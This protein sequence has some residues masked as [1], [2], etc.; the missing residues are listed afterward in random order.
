MQR[1]LTSIQIPASTVKP[2]EAAALEALLRASQSK[3][4]MRI[5]LKPLFFAWLAMSFHFERQQHKTG[6]SFLLRLASL[7]LPVAVIDRYMKSSLDC[8]TVGLS[9]RSH[10]ICHLS[11]PAS[12]QAP[13]A[14]VCASATIAPRNV[15]FQHMTR[16]MA[17]HGFPG[18]P[19]VLRQ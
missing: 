17:G 13:G 2:A 5:D 9:A 11:L 1:I 10:P 18:P 15:L 12:L 7:R 6:E 19:R 8:W 16:G 4:K 14:A 3:P